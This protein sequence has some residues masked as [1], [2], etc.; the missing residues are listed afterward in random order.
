VESARHD[1]ETW[2]R[3]AAQAGNPEA[4]HD[5]GQLLEE[6]GSAAEAE[7][8]YR[9]AAEAGL[10]AAGTSLAGLLDE[11][12]STAQAERWYRW[13]AEAGDLDGIYNVG[14]LLARRGDNDEA[15]QW[16]RSAAEAGD[17]DA[18]MSLAALCHQ[19][20]ATDEA[21]RW[22]RT[23]AEGGN[24]DAGFNVGVVLEGRGETEEAGRWYSR[25]AEAGST[26]AAAALVTL[27]RSETTRPH[28]PPDPPA[29]Q[30]A[31]PP[32][33]PAPAAFSAPAPE[34]KT[35]PAWPPAP[36][37]A[38]PPAADQPA[39]PP[40]PS[41]P[42]S[43]PPAAPSW[44]PAPAATPPAPPAPAV[45]PAPVPQPAPAAPPAPAPAAPQ[46][47]TL[48]APPAGPGQTEPEE[49]SD[50][51]RNL[52]ADHVAT[53]LGKQRALGELLGDHRW[54]LDVQAG[55]VDFGEGRVYPVQLLGTESSVTNTWLWAWAN[56]LSEIPSEV[57]GA[58]VRLRD[59]G[60]DADV[61]ELT[62][63]IFPLSPEGGHLL[64]LV[65]SGVCEADG[66]YRGPY[67]N[68]AVYFLIFG[69]GLETKP[70]TAQEMAVTLQ[71]VVMTFGVDHRRM[72]V[73]FLRQQG[74][75]ITEEG[76]VVR[77]AGPDGAEVR[78]RF[79]E[80]GRLDGIS[81]VG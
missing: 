72:A 17:T 11:R 74:W 37:A 80:Q 23:A 22:W 52:L 73:E 53:S 8:W 28:L 47:A 75:A 68:G 81:A 71:G 46:A 78:L 60:R 16:F 24:A 9:R 43:A 29:A 67:D 2:L 70:R 14:A 13:A 41:L 62:R 40:A 19:R 21:E 25:A 39:R 48:G 56:D 4:A 45:P 69:T 61:P 42:P 15:E 77:A 26:Q 12:G 18:V 33:P 55:T 49:A 6:R 5:L 27:T 44:P 34:L 59:V 76:R 57:L 63:P 31:A 66:Y 79:D 38:A 54:F 3:D 65:A 20:G 50:V 1:A 35:P 7:R 32:V 36:P 64:A 58:A 30:P 10:A 51:F